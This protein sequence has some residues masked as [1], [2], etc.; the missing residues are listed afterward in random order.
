VKECLVHLNK[1]HEQLYVNFKELRQIVMD[2]RSQMS[3]T[4]APS[5]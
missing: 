4:C 1:K 3:D 2:M 5:Y